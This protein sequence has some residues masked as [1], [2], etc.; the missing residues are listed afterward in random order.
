MTSS[1]ESFAN[2]LLESIEK[3]RGGPGPQSLPKA[4]PAARAPARPPIRAKKEV[5]MSEVER[6]MRAALAQLQNR[7]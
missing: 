3:R 5:S 7:C 4:T 2:N 6:R 1:R